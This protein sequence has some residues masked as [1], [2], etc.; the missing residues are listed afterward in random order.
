V[1]LANLATVGDLLV[2]HLGSIEQI[3]ELY[4]VLAASGPSALHDKAGWLGLVLQVNPD[5]QDCGDPERG[6]EG[7]SGTVRRFPSNIAPMAPN[8]AAHCTASNTGAKGKQ[9]RGSAH[10]PGGDPISVAGGGV[11]YPRAVTNNELR[12]GS[13]LPTTQSLGDA[14]WVGLLTAALH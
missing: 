3:F 14:S 7:Y 2:R 12:V 11:A 13:A 8:V 4:P 5:P 1:T 6:G 9:V 10:V